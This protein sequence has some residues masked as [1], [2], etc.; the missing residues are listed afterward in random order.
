MIM[1]GSQHT[2]S[3]TNK[4]CAPDHVVPK[5]LK[6]TPNAVPTKI[7]AKNAPMNADLR[8]GGAMS[9]IRGGPVVRTPASPSPLKNRDARRTI[10]GVPRSQLANIN[11][12]TAQHKKPP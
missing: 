4:A 7:I 1:N 8:S 2:V 11:A 10:L 6:P 9:V 5:E 3:T 12:E